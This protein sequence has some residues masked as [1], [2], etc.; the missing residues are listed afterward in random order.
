MRMKDE[1]LPRSE[2]G[3]E[4]NKKNLKWET[5]YHIGFRLDCAMYTLCPK[6]S[7]SWG[8]CKFYLFLC[9]SWKS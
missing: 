4:V 6:I 7:L 8:L 3:K 9:L 2:H 1:S 5:E